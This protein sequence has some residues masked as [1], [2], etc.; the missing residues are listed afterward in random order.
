MAQAELAIFDIAPGWQSHM[1]SS[2]TQT[3]KSLER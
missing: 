3:G 2:L 1:L